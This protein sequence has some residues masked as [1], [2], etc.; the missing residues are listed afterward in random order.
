MMTIE[1]FEK[2]IERM[3]ELKEA[4][5]EATNFKGYVKYDE[6]VTISVYHYN[7]NSDKEY[8]ILG[9]Y[10]REA[11]NKQLDIMLENYDSC[12]RRLQENGINVKNEFKEDK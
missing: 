9:Q 11:L 10:I 7:S 1:Q 3:K 5:K 2:E 8:K 12:I 6:K 4:I